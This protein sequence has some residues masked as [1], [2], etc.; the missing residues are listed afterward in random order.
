M[1]KLNDIYVFISFSLY[2]NSRYQ[3]WQ[4][5]INIYRIVYD[6]HISLLFYYIEG[7]EIRDLL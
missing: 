1:N 6:R 5:F 2:K 4:N 3:N 7:Y